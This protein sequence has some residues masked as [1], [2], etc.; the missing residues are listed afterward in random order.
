MRYFFDIEKASSSKITSPIIVDQTF[1][2][3]P[4]KCQ[5]SPGDTS[6]DQMAVVFSP[7]SGIEDLR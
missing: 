5:A 4:W 7:G 1:N 3:L 2:V 6:F